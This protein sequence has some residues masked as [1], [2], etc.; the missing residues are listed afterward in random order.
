MGFDAFSFNTLF[1]L[2]CRQLFIHNFTR[3]SLNA[4]NIVSKTCKGV[5][6]LFCVILLSFSLVL[7]SNMFYREMG[8]GA[9]CDR[10]AG[11]ATYHEHYVRSQSGTARFPALLVKKKTS[12]EFGT[13]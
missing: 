4:R 7:A 2:A 3:L 9:C 13:E 12:G 5:D 6:Y 11:K 1:F 8:V 10:V